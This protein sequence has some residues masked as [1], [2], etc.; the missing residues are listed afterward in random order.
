M[1]KYNFRYTSCIILR[2][3]MLGYW[4]K[5]GDLNQWIK[6][7]YIANYSF[8][9]ASTKSIFYGSFTYQS[10]NLL[11]CLFS[12]CLFNYVHEKIP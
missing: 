8:K 4:F 5:P 7:G 3:E 2:L 11:G 12:F 10:V 9:V 1:K 6:K